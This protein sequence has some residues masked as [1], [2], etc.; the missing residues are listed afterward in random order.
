MNEEK[1]LYLKTYSDISAFL[2]SLNVINQKNCT[3]FYLDV[4]DQEQSRIGLEA[5]IDLSLDIMIAL[6][7]EICDEYNLKLPFIDNQSINLEVLVQL[8]I[9]LEVEYNNGSS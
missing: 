8:V 1:G 4:L 6:I 3:R 2:R 7:K 9:N 5:F